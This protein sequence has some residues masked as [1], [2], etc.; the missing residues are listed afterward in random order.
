MKLI[1][2]LITVL[3][4]STTGAD[5]TAITEDGKRAILKSDGTWEYQLDSN[6]V[7]SHGKFRNATWGMSADQVRKL[8]QGEPVHDKDDVIGYSTSVVGLDCWAAYFFVDDK[9]VRGRYVINEAHSNLN[10][11]I[12]D[13]EN[14]KQALSKK[15]GQPSFDNKNWRN[16]LYQDDF[17]KWG[18]A[19]SLGHLVY[20]ASWE[21]EDS[22]IYLS[23]TGENYETSLLIEYASKAFSGLEQ[24]T[25]EA[26]QLDDL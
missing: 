7:Q 23:L 22:D 19:I 20:A 17:D 25:R 14:L 6:E 11:F 2:L 5:V 18:F 1:F 4:Y 21:T 10:D 8:E 9:F 3:S 24:K 15:Y 16:D 13:F 12:N 26:K